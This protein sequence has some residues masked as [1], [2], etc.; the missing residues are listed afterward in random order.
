MINQG[1]GNLTAQVIQA[2]QG[3]TINKDTLLKLVEPL[4]RQTPRLAA[5]NLR[6]CHTC[7]PPCGCAILLWVVLPLLD[8]QAKASSLAA[9]SKSQPTIRFQRSLPLLR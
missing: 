1:Q 2:H 6:T 8:P 3:E 9:S 4:W 7:H 5:Q